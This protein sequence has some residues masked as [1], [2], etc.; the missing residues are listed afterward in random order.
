M[1]EL[2]LLILQEDVNVEASSHKAKT[3]FGMGKCSYNLMARALLREQSPYVLVL[4]E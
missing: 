2:I 4:P 3:R 1:S